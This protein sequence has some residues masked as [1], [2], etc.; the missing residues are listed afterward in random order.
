MQQG[1]GQG[2]A[3]PNNEVPP[4]DQA[5]H[6]RAVA[7]VRASRDR[8]RLSTAR[9]RARR[10]N[11]DAAA[12][13]PDQPGSCER[14]V[15][16]EFLTLINP[17]DP[18]LSRTAPDPNSRLHLARFLDR[19]ERGGRPARPPPGRA[20]PADSSRITGSDIR[21]EVMRGPGCAHA[22]PRL[23]GREACARHARGMREACARHARGMR[24]ACATRLS[25]S[26]RR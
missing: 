18:G 11:R 10:G 23:R 19:F 12:R 2:V 22:R 17:R 6:G 14:L 4:A 13:G 5:R 20:R 15:L 26:L 8:C 3:E 21:Q 25:P 7:P 1:R 24:E 9:R 16:G